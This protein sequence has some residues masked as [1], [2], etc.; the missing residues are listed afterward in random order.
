MNYDSVLVIGMG[1][2]AWGVF[3]PLLMLLRLRKTRKEATYLKTELKGILS[4]LQEA[5]IYKHKKEQ[6][7]A[8]RVRQP[9]FASPK[10]TRKT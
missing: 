7:L 8:S 10:Y 1:L 4:M 5:E 9:I 6:D 2:L 3:I